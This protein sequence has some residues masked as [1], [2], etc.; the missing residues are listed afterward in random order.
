LKVPNEHR[1]LGMLVSKEH[2]RVHRAAELRDTTVLELL[3]STDAF[4]RPDRFEKLLLACEADARG[5]GPEL[6]QRS[7]EQGR[8][9]RRWREVAAAVKPD[10]QVLAGADG[11][12][13]AQH[14]R[15]ARIAAIRE[16]RGAMTRD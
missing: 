8:L 7:Y 4:R 1:E 14:L 16:V 11:P 5:R 2:Q 15:S 9:L 10:P 6:R 12:A 3:E 13:I